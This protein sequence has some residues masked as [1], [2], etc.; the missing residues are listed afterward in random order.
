[1]GRSVH[2]VWHLTYARAN[3]RPMWG[4]MEK[5]EEDGTEREKCGWARR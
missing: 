5:V 2:H 1:M 4:K 3:K